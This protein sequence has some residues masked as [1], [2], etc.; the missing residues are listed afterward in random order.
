MTTRLSLVSALLLCLLQA[1]CC[2]PTYEE[3]LR[4]CL[5]SLQGKDAIIEQQRMSIE[6]L[7]GVLANKHEEVLMHRGTPERSG[8][9][10]V[11]WENRIAVLEAELDALKLNHATLQ[12]R[13]ET[14]QQR[15][16]ECQQQ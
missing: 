2:D 7:R 16:Q 10:L 4:D 11:N 13:H 12:R 3:E 1:G 5:V 14:L 6:E 15:L 9:E 8:R